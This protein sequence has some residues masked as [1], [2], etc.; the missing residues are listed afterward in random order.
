VLRIVGLEGQ[1][2]NVALDAQFNPKEV[3]V[4]RA[5]EWHLQP[6]QGP[7]DL[8]FSTSGGATMAFELMFDGFETSTSVQP[9]VAKLHQLC[10][11]DSGLKR[12]P[13]VRIIFSNPRRPGIIPAF[14]GVVELLSIKYLMFDPNGVP[15]RATVQLRLKDARNLKAGNP[16]T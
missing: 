9:Q 2:E 15:L 13:K 4:D 5:M 1:A 14:E 10:D 3:S 6:Q 11:I 12:P 8:E 7:A 16:G